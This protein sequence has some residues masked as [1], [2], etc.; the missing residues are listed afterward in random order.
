VVA[1]SGETGLTTIELRPIL[2]PG[3]VFSFS[4]VW[5]TFGFITLLI[6]VA[7]AV[8][9]Y[10]AVKT[11]H[12]GTILLIIWSMATLVLM[13]EYR[14]F[15][16]YFA[17]NAALLAGWFTWYL[18]C[19]FRNIDWGF[20]HTAKT[21]TWLSRNWN[22]LFAVIA[23]T[24]LLVV[25]I[26][27][28]TQMAI[29]QAKRALFVPPDSWYNTLEWVDEN[30]PENSLILSWW[31]YGYWIKRI[32]NCNIY[33]NPSQ[34]NVPVSNTARMFLDGEIIEADYLILDHTITTGKMWAVATWAGKHPADFSNI[35]YIFKYERYTPVKLY[36]PEY[37]QT[38]AVRLYNFNGE[39]V[40]PNQSTVINFNPSHGVLLSVDVY[41]TYEEAIGHVG[42]GE[43]LVG[44]NPFISPVPLE[45]ETGYVLVYESEQRINGI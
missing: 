38:L 9:A 28:N 25:M 2:Y 13:L 45:K 34:D 32:A 14:R 26:I 36:Y 6:P 20:Q 40:I 24:I 42:L 1:I 10:R 33:V 8:L 19:C 11:G 12:S 16:Y 41:A 44:T 17:V 5:A 39:A 15:A 31:D 3:G 27:P 4:V 29:T 18:W 37:Y 23:I 7:L 21:K 22:A 30:T 35:Y 43:R